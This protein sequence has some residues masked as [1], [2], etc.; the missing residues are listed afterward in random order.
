MS[1]LS[2]FTDFFNHT[3]GPAYLTGPDAVINDAQLRNFE[4]FDALSRARKAIQGGPQIKDMILLSDPLTADTYLPG[5]S[6]SVINVAGGSTITQNWRHVRVYVTWNE[7]EIMLNEGGSAAGAGQFHQFKRLK[8]FKYMQAYTSLMNKLERLMIASASLANQDS[9]NS[10][11]PY[12]IF[13]TVTSDGLAPSG[14]TTVQGIN[15][16]TESKWRNQ[17]A[18]YTYATPFNSDTGIIAGFDTMSQLVKFK[19][20]V[21]SPDNSKFT[22]SELSSCVV[23]TNREG[24]ADYMKALRS[25]NDITRVG[26]Q[27]PAYPQPEFDGVKV[28]ACEGFDDQSTFTSGQPGY[29]FLNMNFLKLVFYSEKW[30]AKGNPMVFPD[31]PDTTVVWFDTWLNVMNQSRQRQGYLAAA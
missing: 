12:S 19:A 25:A 26:A 29:V 14:F 6:A 8:D 5:E 4:A 3:T 20:P 16:T 21:I 1:A 22:P 28:V 17:T 13:T 9:T 11:D 23:L 10:K 27:N 7:K 2:T 30:M 15:P 18:T 24:R 31:K